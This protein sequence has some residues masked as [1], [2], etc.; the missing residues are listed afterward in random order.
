MI[1]APISALIPSPVT[2]LRLQQKSNH[3][4]PAAI[5][6]DD[7][8]KGSSASIDRANAS[9]QPMICHSS[10]EFENPN[11]P[12]SD[13]PS[14]LLTSRGTPDAVF[15]FVKRLESLC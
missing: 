14:L 15:S 10:R 7:D 9:G 4:K 8:E 6:Y 12:S 2:S 5:L 13:V 1:S 3:R 11:R